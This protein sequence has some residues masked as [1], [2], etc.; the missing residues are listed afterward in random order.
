MFPTVFP[1]VFPSVSPS[2]LPLL[3]TTFPSSPPSISFLPTPLGCFRQWDE[4][5]SAVRQASESGSGGVFVICPN[6]EM[7]VDLFPDPDVTPIVIASNDI[8]IQCGILGDID[9]RCVVFG[10]ERHFQIEDDASG[11]QFS[12]IRFVGA[13]ITSI[14][15]FGGSEA[16]VQFTDCGWENGLGSQAVLIYGGSDDFPS[17]PNDGFVIPDQVSSMAVQFVDCFFD[18]NTASF[19]VVTN[20]GGRLSLERT[21]FSDN[22]AAFGVLTVTGSGSASVVDSCFVSNTATMDLGLIVIGET[23]TLAIAE[24]NFG[25]ANSVGQSNNC[26]EILVMEADG[27][28]CIPFDADECSIVD[29]PPT[30]VPTEAPSL[31]E[32]TPLPSMEMEPTRSPT[33]G[34]SDSTQSPSFGCFDEWD[35]LSLA[36]LA[37]CAQGTG[38]LFVLCSDTVFDVDAFPDSLISPI[39]LHSS[40]FTIQCGDDGA[41]SNNCVVS[42]GVTQFKIRNVV[43]LV[44]FIGVTFEKSRGISIHAAATAESTAFFIDCEWRN[45]EGT[46]AILMLELDRD[47]TAMTVGLLRSNFTD[48]DVVDACVLNVGGLLV[49]EETLFLRN[50]ARD[51]AIGVVE[52]GS[53]SVFNSCFVQNSGAVS[54][55]GDSDIV[56]E[57]GNFGLDNG[58]CNGILDQDDDI[59]V[60]CGNACSAFDADR[61]A[62]MD[63]DPDLVPTVSPTMTL[64]PICIP[65]ASPVPSTSPTLTPRPTELTAKPTVSFPPTDEPTNQNPPTDSPTE[66][67]TDSP[68]E[69]ATTDSPTEEATTDSPTEEAPTDSPTEEAPTDSPTEEAPTDSPTEEAPTDSPTKEATTDSPTEEAPTDSPTEEAPTDS[70]TKEATTDSPT[71]EA[72]TDSPTEEAPTDSPTKE[73]TTDS[74]TEEAP[75]DSPTEEAPTDSPTEESPTGS[76]PEEAPT[77]SPTGEAPTDSPAEEP[78]TDS[79]TKQEST[80]S[81]TEATPTDSPTEEA[82]T[83]SPT[84]ETLTD[85]PTEETPTDSPTEETPTD[86]PTEETPTDSPTEQAPTD[87]PTELAP[88][89]SPTELAPTDSP[90]ELAPTDSPIELAPTGSPTEL[91]PTGSPT[92]LAPTG[93]PTELAPT[94]SPTE[95]PTTDS[96][97]EVA[98]TDSPTEEPTT[99]SPSDPPPSV[100]PTEGPTKT[101]DE[102]AAPTNGELPSLRPSS[103]PSTRPT[104]LRLPSSAPSV[105]PSFKPSIQDIPTLTE[106][107]TMEMSFSFDY[108]FFYNFN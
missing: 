9:T 67:P 89:D 17:D 51:G 19:A 58:Q 63:F 61:C 56:R 42:G 101:P 95:E 74:P 32:P 102:T 41:R 11:I 38:G 14:N 33:M 8:T 21:I 85:S 105:V 98:P 91:A 18:G 27:E 72:P 55:E 7:D 46:S 1:S 3:P 39:I 29:L 57:E 48:N 97:T 22:E 69:E 83:D 52:S 86:S 107:P 81:P 78:P 20:V 94:G 45:N 79:P 59:A 104:R 4:L 10:G 88:T 16:N 36:I 6:T 2:L 84:E 35:R 26:T 99:A 60:L 62:V 103:I 64:Q 100:E 82:P 12:G 68:T 37:A 76:P 70:P 75:T 80:D 15:A 23:S 90:T 24:G 87:S 28:V 54:I 44:Q 30:G 31:F 49:V 96:P 71:E 73:A 77:D 5:S 53:I 47:E 93:S 106:G 65:T 43:M 50:L 108:N 40:D 66:E 34:S 13:L 92:E 25:R